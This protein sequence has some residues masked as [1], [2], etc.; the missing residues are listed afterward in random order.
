MQIVAGDLGGTK[1]LLRI[2]DVQGG[3]Y[4]VLRDERYVSNNFTGFTPM[5]REFIGDAGP[6]GLRA[7]CFGVAGP[8]TEGHGSQ[9]AMLTNLPWVL[10]TDEIS[11]AFSFPAVRLVNDF[12][13][14]GYGIEALGPEDIVTLQAGRE[15]VQAPRVVLG[16]GTGLGQGI[17]VWQGDH[18][19]ALPTEG[20]HAGFAPMDELQDDLL[21]YLRIQH[22]RV[23]CERILSGP[24]LVT[25]YTFL[26]TRDVHPESESLAAA[27]RN[28][29]PAPAI[30]HAALKLND[31]LACA[32]LD[33]FVSIYGAHAGDLA[34]TVMAS[35]GVYIAGG[36]AAQIAPWLNS[37]AFISAFNDKGRMS[38]LT[39]NMPVRL[40]MNPMVGVMG[41]AL[42]AA[43]MAGGGNP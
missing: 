1:T 30:T 26:R 13:A 42:V 27:L 5:L 9:R 37:A 11:R 41:A 15:R 4:R 17:L 32:T 21:R 20:G 22:G 18:Y 6:D 3:K 14:T 43:R 29:E 19:R 7:A 33:L 35:G 28:A 23:S 34:L 38:V 25:L 31:P 12:Q 10:D 24:G 39:R 16:A 2:V 36:I 40:V 8:V